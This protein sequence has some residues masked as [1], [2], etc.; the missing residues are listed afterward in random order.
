MNNGGGDGA[1]WTI[2]TRVNEIAGS[3]GGGNFGY[4]N[5]NFA[6]RLSLEVLVE[7]CHTPKDVWKVI[8]PGRQ[9]VLGR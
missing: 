8:I 5:D 7:H 9:M 4:T 2:F 3:M 6:I 1:Q